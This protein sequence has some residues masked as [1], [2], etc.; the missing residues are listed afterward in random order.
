M[1]RVA[2]VILSGLSLPSNRS[3]VFSVVRES[4]ESGSGVVVVALGVVAR[5]SGFGREG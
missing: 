4:R 5:V 2:R 3:A 1:E